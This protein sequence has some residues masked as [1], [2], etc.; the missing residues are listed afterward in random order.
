MISTL[1]VTKLMMLIMMM[2]TRRDCDALRN[3][4]SSAVGHIS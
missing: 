2:T 3:L 4:Y 1:H